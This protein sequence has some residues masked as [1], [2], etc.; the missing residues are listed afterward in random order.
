MRESEC[1]V[2]GKKLIVAETTQEQKYD[3]RATKYWSYEKD[4]RKRPYC[5]AKCGEIDSENK[6][7]EEE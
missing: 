7:K 4:S 3:V 1:V 6:N 2:C 5:S